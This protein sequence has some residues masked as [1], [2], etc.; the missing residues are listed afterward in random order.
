[1]LRNIA[2]KIRALNNKSKASGFVFFIWTVLI[3]VYFECV[4]RAVTTGRILSPSI[5]ISLFFDAVWSGVICLGFMLLPKGRKRRYWIWGILLIFTIIFISQA[6]YFKMMQ[7]FYT[8][9]S[10]ENAGKAFEFA[11]MALSGLIAHFMSVILFSVPLLSWILMRKRQ[12]YQTLEAQT[13]RKGFKGTIILM[14]I[15]S[16]LIGL[17]IVQWGDKSENS[18]YSLYYTMDFPEFSVDN[19]GLL[20]YMRLDAKRYYFGFEASLI[21]YDIDDTILDQIEDEIDKDEGSSNDSAVGG[22]TEDEALLEERPT[23]TYEP[24]ILNIDFNTLISGTSDPNIKEMHQYFSQVEP[25]DKNAFTGKYKDYNLIFIT[26]EGFSHL[27]I[28]PVITPTL[29]KLQ[30][31]GVNFTNFYTPIWG[32]S[33]SDGEYVATT[34]LI[35]KSG[36]WS[37][38]HSRNNAMPFAMGNQLKA[39]GYV[40]KA[41]HNHTYTYYDRNLSHPNMGYDYVGVGNGLEIKNTWPESDLEMM[42]IT[43]KDYV[44]LPKFHTYY[45]TVSGHMYYNFNDNAMAYKNREVVKDLPYSDAVKAYLATQVEFDHAMASLLKQLEASGR[46]DNTLIAIS[47][48]HYPY[49]LTVDEIEELTG[50]EIDE[51]FDLYRNAFILYAKGMEPLTVDRPT[52]S[53]DIIPTLSNLMGLDFD[54]RMLMGVDMFSDSAPLVIFSNRSFISEYGAYNSKTGVFTPNKVGEKLNEDLLTTYRK[55][56]SNRI[57]E[58]FFYSARI[59]ETNYYSQIFQNN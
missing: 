41:Y 59:L 46:L 9:Y 54:S 6:V 17:G 36:V 3:F 43:V 55:A 50:H 4:L 15:L 45:M 7:T 35:P 16:H 39:K 58:K 14:I 25:T 32:V 2:Y 8:L 23:V 51:N 30:H 13:F 57:N 20:T 24:Q 44:D 49:G 28:D 37:Y 5:Y 34:G 11:G 29:Y 18:P 27:A 56:I 42:D 21:A 12:T 38:R 52:S 19:L 40:T 53:L 47:A 33:T 48:D 10:A 26:A 22:N 1:M 31:E